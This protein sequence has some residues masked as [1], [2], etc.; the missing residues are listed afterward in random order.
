MKILTAEQMSYVDKTT[1][2]SGTPGLTL[3]SNAG[4]AVFELVAGLPGIDSD[5]EI[6]I[7]A[8]K[9][10]N[11]GD[12]FRVAEL[13]AQNGFETAVYLLGK[14]SDIR[15]DAAV[16]MNDAVNAGL[17]IVEITCDDDIGMLSNAFITTS[18]IVDAIFGTG[19]KGE[20][21]GLPASVIDLINK[22]NAQVV[23]VDIPSGINA[24]TGKMSG[25]TVQ[26]DYTVTFGALKVGHVLMPGKAVCGDVDLINIGF[27]GE[28]MD[29]VEP[30]GNT[31]TVTEAAGLIPRRPCDAHK[32]SAGR[33][34][35]IAGSVGMTGAASLTSHAAMRVG[36][37]MVTVGCPASLN[38]ILEVK[39]TE[40]MTLPLP[41]VRK[42]R[43]L[44]LRALGKI[45][46]SVRNADV[47]AV[48]P[49]LGRY[50][51]TAEL[52]RR[53]I[54][55][56]SGRVILDADGINAFKGDVESLR[57][58]RCGIVLTPHAGELS[59][60]TGISI[61]EIIDD[62]VSQARKASESTGKIILL[63]GVPTVIA[64]PDGTVWIN[65][66][67]NEGMATAGMGD[68]L[69]GTI[70]GLAAQGLDLFEAAILGAYI[71]GIAGETASKKKGIHGVMSSDV[72]DFLPDAMLYILNYEL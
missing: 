47:V 71:H 29:S 15:G 55:E 42:K 5:T 9:G 63:K 54:S 67:G 45:R 37:G 35:V 52:V 49:G 18:V 58:A 72:L 38:D 44:S 68:V 59:A 13:L 61:E 66:S 16:C 51:E 33:V 4:S 20:I 11:G 22:S 65:G 24:S 14:T 43:C 12:G 3:M 31:L 23:A 40:V 39:L 69:T 32:G 10:N 46:E 7:I 28:V 64:G 57:A 48:G 34:F 30:F 2:E 19:L 70:S 50:F 62:P 36:A 26:A 1:I 6:V 53:F 27:S 56:Y 60:L 8:G 41:E 17:K 21:T 25:F